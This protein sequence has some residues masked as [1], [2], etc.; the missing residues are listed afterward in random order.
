V[1]ADSTGISSR[2]LR[3]DGRRLAAAGASDARAVAIELSCRLSGLTQQAIG[4]YF[5]GVGS[6]AI[7]KT[8]MAIEAVR[9]T[10]AP[11]LRRDLIADIERRLLRMGR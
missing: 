11:A 6:A 10:G 7:G 9:R 1:V 8:R 4:A 3:A 2:A 5:G